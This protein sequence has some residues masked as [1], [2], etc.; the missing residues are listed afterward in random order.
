MAHDPS[1][2]DAHLRHVN[3]DQDREL[4]YWAQKWG[5][6]PGEI[7][8]AVKNVGT[9]AEAVAREVVPRRYERDDWR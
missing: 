9:S 1:K 6:T 2:G 4:H 5:V 3:I 8:E 7:R